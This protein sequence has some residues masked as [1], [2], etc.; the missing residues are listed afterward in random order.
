[1]EIITD[2]FREEEIGIFKKGPRRISPSDEG[3]R[4]GADYTIGARI[5][6]TRTRPQ[7][8]RPIGSEGNSL[9]PV[10]LLQMSL[11]FY[12]GSACIMDYSFSGIPLPWRRWRIPT[13]VCGETTGDLAS[14]LQGQLE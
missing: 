12:T 1:M 6:R 3:E 4:C 5:V 10:L 2:K 13:S 11:T 8:V 7:L 14:A 9:R